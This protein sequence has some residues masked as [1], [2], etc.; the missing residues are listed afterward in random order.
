MHLTE[1]KM[2]NKM[3]LKQLLNLYCCNVLIPE[4]KICRTDFAVNGL[5]LFHVLDFNCS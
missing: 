1:K 3:N 5:F 4:V 2:W